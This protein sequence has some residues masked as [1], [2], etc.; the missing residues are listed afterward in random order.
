M[1]I[2]LHFLLHYQKIGQNFS[3]FSGHTDYQVGCCQRSIICLARLSNQSLVAWVMI[4]KILKNDFFLTFLSDTF[5]SA[6]WILKIVSPRTLEKFHQKSQQKILSKFLSYY[7]HCN[8]V[9]NVL[10]K[11]SQ[12]VEV[13]QIEQCVLDTIATKQLS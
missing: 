2:F 9:Q 1:L 7:F 4:L 6:N 11:H 10:P 3:Q 13:H 8:I 12:R 5:F